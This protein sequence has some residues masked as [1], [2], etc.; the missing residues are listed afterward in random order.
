MPVPKPYIP[1]RKFL[2][3]GA[4]PDRKTNLSDF[5]TDLEVVRESDG[6]TFATFDG[7]NFDQTTRGLERWRINATWIASTA[8]NSV[9]RALSPLV[10]QVV[11][12]E[13]GP[14]S[15]KPTAESPIIRGRCFIS[16]LP[17]VPSGAKREVGTLQTSW[18]TSG[19]VLIATP[20][21]WWRR[22]HGLTSEPTGFT[23]VQAVA[24]SQEE[25]A[26]GAATSLDLVP[27]LGLEGPPRSLTLRLVRAVV[28]SGQS[29][30]QIRYRAGDDGIDERIYGGLLPANSDQTPNLNGIARGTFSHD[31][32]QGVNADFIHWR[33]FE[34]QGAGA[35]PTSLADALGETNNLADTVGV[36]SRG[37]LDADVG[38]AD[39]NNTL[40]V[41]AV[42][43]RVKAGQSVSS[44]AYRSSGAGVNAAMWCGLVRESGGFPDLTHA[45][46]GLAQRTTPITSRW[47][48]TQV[49]IPR[50]DRFNAGDHFYVVSAHWQETATPHGRFQVNF[51]NQGWIS[52]FATANDPRVQFNRWSWYESGS[53]Y[54]TADY[55]I[56]PAIAAGTT[57][58]VGLGHYRADNPSRGRVHVS[59]DGGSEWITDLLA[60]YAAVSF[61][62]WAWT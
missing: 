43:C 53:G 31:P 1:S 60:D 23:V 29:I 30:S 49:A 13:A 8:T 27:E 41:R 20:R 39:I 36:G 61:P 50:A 12:F 9:R 2:A 48:S 40:V 37:D 4:H 55:P 16:S 34:R 45:G 15:D 5:L 26:R 62:Q 17:Y 22:W 18:T 10:G 35:R 57:F 28:K 6:Q 38:I 46:V 19:S 21:L 24:A 58:Y 7:D 56:S 54:E 32:S 42:Q 59:F 25:A 51:D 52:N 33:R 3:I 47:T 14:G 44:V 11:Y